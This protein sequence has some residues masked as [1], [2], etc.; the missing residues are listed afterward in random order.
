MIKTAL[1]ILTIIVL[2]PFSA[3]FAQKIDKQKQ[4]SL[5]QGKIKMDV[6]FINPIPSDKIADI[7]TGA[8]YSLIPIANNCPECKFAVEDIDST[9][10]NP[11]NLLKKIKKAATL[12]LSTISHSIM[13]LKKNSPCLQ[14]HTIKS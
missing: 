13:A 14:P 4:D 2:L 6:D 11:P 12:H 8:G 7:G 3:S 1:S 5:H 9:T 10:C